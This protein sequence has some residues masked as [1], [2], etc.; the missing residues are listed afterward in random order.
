MTQRELTA[1]ALKFMTLLSMFYMLTSFPSL[2]LGLVQAG[3]VRP[4]VYGFF[5][6]LSIIAIFALWLMWYISNKLI[7]QTNQQQAQYFTQTNI[8]VCF[9][10]IGIFV[11]VSDISSIVNTI[12]Y[13]IFIVGTDSYDTSRQLGDRIWLASLLI[14]ISIAVSFIV[15]RKFLAKQL[16]K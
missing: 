13:N 6:L 7:V 15:F 3:E 2:V 9:A 16:I 10:L 1:L 12:G 4:I 5:A 11:L 14:K 8:A